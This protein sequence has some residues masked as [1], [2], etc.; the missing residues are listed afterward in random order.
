MPFQSGSKRSIAAYVG[1]RTLE[2]LALLGQSTR[3]ADPSARA[4]GN[5][6]PQDKTAF[7]RWYRVLG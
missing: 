2:S 4:D 7:C 5:N 6:S 1:L 3:L